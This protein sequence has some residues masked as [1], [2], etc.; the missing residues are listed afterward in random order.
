MKLQCNLYY[1][2]HWVMYI[3]VLILCSSVKEAFS[4]LKMT[5]EVKM[6]SILQKLHCNSSVYIAAATLPLGGSGWSVLRPI[7]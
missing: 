1:G 2:H 6:V 7:A 3:L 5:L 4:I